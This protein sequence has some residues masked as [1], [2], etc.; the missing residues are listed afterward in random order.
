MTTVQHDE[1]GPEA[2]PLPGAAIAPFGIPPALPTQTGPAGLRFD[3]NYGARLFLPPGQWQVKILDDSENILYACETAG[4]WVIGSKK[5]FLPVRLVVFQ[6]GDQVLDHSLNLHGRD[7]LIYF[8]PDAGLG[9]AL[10][11]IGLVEKFQQRHQGR[12]ECVLRPELVELLAPKYPELLLSPP[13]EVICQEP[14]ATYRL[15]LFSEDRQADHQPIDFRQVGLAASAAYILDLDP[16]EVRPRLNLDAP[17]AI[18]EPYVC[19]AVQSTSQA[20]LWNNGGGWPGVIEF[21]QDLGYRVLCLD[22]HRAVGSGYVWN[23]IPH[24]VEDFTGDRP[25]Q[26]RVD[27]L[28]HADF[29][30]GLSSGLSWL[31]WAAGLPVVLISGFTRP[32]CEFR[33]PYRVFNRIGCS[34]CWEDP[35][36]RFDP[37]D[38]FWCPRH[39]GTTRQFECSRLITAK[40][41]IGHIQRLMADQR[42]LPPRIRE[43][44][45]RLI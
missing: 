21:L 45:K 30:V 28:R 33:T 1:H 18:A 10:G 11:W 4:G 2:A 9:D 15:G 36:L 27:I 43:S 8:P 22:R 24:G 39:Q 25:L 44:M 32:T 14:Y 23:R 13:G 38:F 17:R 5:Y 16:A 29:F 35:A 7:V 19:L 12:I 41:V 20:K 31:A 34:G 6:D 3:F 26:E 42:L 37:E 40:Q